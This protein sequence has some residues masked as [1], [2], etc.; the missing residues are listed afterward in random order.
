[1]LFPQN[2]VHSLYTDNCALNETFRGSKKMR[3]NRLKI[4]SILLI[5]VLVF[6]LAA[7][8]T[9]TDQD[10]ASDVSTPVETAEVTEE[11]EA[12]AEDI[13]VYPVINP[14]R[15][16]SIQEAI[17]ITGIEMIS[18]KPELDRN[19][20]P[21]GMD[22]IYR[23]PVV[24]M[25][26]SF[27]F[28]IQLDQVSLTK[29]G[30]SPPKKYFDYLHENTPIEC[31]DTYKEIEG[32]GEAAFSYCT[33]DSDVWHQVIF[34]E[35]FML[36]VYLSEGTNDSAWAQETLAKLADRTFE[37]L[38]SVLENPEVEAAPGVDTV[39]DISE[40]GVTITVPAKF[41][42]EQNEYGGIEI[43]SSEEN[44]ELTLFARISEGDSVASLRDTN[45][46]NLDR[47]VSEGKV[48]IK[49]FA[50][51]EAYCIGY[52]DILNAIWL[53]FNDDEGIAYYVELLL[54]S[55]D[56]DFELTADVIMGDPDVMT[57]INSI[58]FP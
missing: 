58:T 47:G 11:A 10:E 4:V 38:K 27:T 33:Q 16:L 9:K 49:T 55:P 20:P 48:E 24:D 26:Y 5:F 40:T 29:E 15:L 56:T 2:K 53:V 36:N 19:A 17:E 12:P 30:N 6:A 37:N 41:T 31:A 51:K 39:L 44:Y 32:M 13:P 18:E 45:K 25:A 7:C 50:G 23:G 52:P 8:G 54:G 46:A 22:L 57:M 21:N 14:S 1:M 28:W 3:N 34:Y 35:G 43:R 42:Y